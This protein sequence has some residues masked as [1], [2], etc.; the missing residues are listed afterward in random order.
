[1]QEVWSA[2]YNTGCKLTVDARHEMDVCYT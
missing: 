1:M 2:I